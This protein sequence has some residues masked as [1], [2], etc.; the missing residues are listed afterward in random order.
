M[1]VKNCI[2]KYDPLPNITDKQMH[3]TVDSV[4]EFFLEEESEVEEVA[5]HPFFLK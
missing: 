4:N 2:P 1:R 5:I 3:L